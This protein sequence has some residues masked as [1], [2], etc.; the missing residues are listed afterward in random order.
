MN[1]KLRKPRFLLEKKLIFSNLLIFIIF[2]RIK[3]H[4]FGKNSLN[5]QKLIPTKIN[6]LKVLSSR[7]T[8][9]KKSYFETINNS[10]SRAILSSLFLSRQ[11]CVGNVPAINII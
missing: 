8:S 7:Y 1:K 3:F 10:Q 4:D 6:S 2:A 11:K 5:L 9:F